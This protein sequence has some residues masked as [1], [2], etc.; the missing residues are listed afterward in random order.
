MANLFQ[1][2]FTLLLKIKIPSPGNLRT[3][4]MQMLKVAYRSLVS[5][6]SDS[7]SVCMQSRLDS[8]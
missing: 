1:I 5:I 4:G 6:D 2:D 8:K 7:W 3:R